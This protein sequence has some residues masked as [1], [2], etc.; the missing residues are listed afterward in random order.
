MSVTRAPGLVGHD[1]AD[2]AEDGVEFRKSG[3]DQGVGEDVVALG[4]AYDT[5]CADLALT[6]T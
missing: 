6:H 3:V 5:V 2:E 4:Y 1:G